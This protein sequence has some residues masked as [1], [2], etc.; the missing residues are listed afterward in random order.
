MCVGLASW[1]HV[2]STRA[3]LAKTYSHGHLKIG[4]GRGP[5]ATVLG[6]LRGHKPNLY[7]RP[8]FKYRPKFH[9]SV[10]GGVGH[11]KQS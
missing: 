3:R 7:V 11:Y 4:S 1:I 6:L 8:S 9:K 2:I 5:R 10:V